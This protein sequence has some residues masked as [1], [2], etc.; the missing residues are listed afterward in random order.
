MPVELRRRAGASCDRPRSLV[1]RNAMQC[2]Y[3]IYVATLTATMGRWGGCSHVRLLQYDVQDAE[4]RKI[5]VAHTQR[6]YYTAVSIF[7]PSAVPLC[8]TGDI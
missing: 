5:S 6:L 8:S 3:G 4:F 1:G 7:G 2:V